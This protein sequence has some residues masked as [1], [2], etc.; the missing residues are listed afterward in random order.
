MKNRLLLV[1]LLNFIFV[2]CSKN[3]QYDLTQKKNQLN[4]EVQSL[5]KN[6]LKDG[7][8]AEFRNQTKMCGEVNAKN[9]FGGYVGFT[10]FIVTEEKILFENEFQESSYSKKMYQEAWNGYCK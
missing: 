1:L 2:G 5:V 7:K 10:R 6:S 4:L 9:S 3:E 8:S